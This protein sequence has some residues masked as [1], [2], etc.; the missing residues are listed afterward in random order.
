MQIVC[1]SLAILCGISE[2]SLK[3]E[4]RKRSFGDAI[5]AQILPI[6]QKFDALFFTD[7]NVSRS[8]CKFLM[9]AKMYVGECNLSLSCVKVVLEI[10][11]RTLLLGGRIVRRSC[12]IIDY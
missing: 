3:I 9:I 4:T 6:Q 7:F 8:Q 2:R 10:A 1:H 11:G 5:P 12:Q